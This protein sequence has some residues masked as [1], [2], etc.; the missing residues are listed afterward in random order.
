M[1]KKK[2]IVQLRVGLTEKKDQTCCSDDCR[3]SLKI[4]NKNISEKTFDPAKAFLNIKSNIFR[5]TNFKLQYEFLIKTF[6]FVSGLST[7]FMFDPR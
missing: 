6:F 2:L 4:T 5:M 3:F 1:Q 7:H